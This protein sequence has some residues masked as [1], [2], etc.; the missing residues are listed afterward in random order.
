MVRFLAIL[1][2]LQAMISVRTELVTVPV[3]VTDERGAHVDGLVAGDFQIL[4][5]GRTQPIAVFHH[6]DTSVTLGI[7]VDRSQSMRAKQS[8]T[9]IA[10][11]ALLRSGRPDDELFA[12]D[13]NDRI[14][15]ALPA[16]RMFTRDAGALQ[17]ALVEVPAEGRTALYDGVAAALE[18]LQLG[19]AERRI[20]I[21]IS[22]GGDNASLHTYDQIRTQARQ[23]DVVIYGIG[24]MGVGIAEQ[25]ED[26]GLLVKLCKDSGGTAY[27]PHTPSDV[28]AHAA[29]INHAVRQQYTLGFSPGLHPDRDRFR[30][31]EVKV[32]AK[33]KGRLRVRTRAGYSLPGERL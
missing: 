32:T 33:G 26:A 14:V 30:K 24:L 22:D 27:F 19:R 3:T 29:Q 12:V 13:F 20:L 8:A 5:N 1:L 16:D 23:S 9:L 10:V 18:H 25:D 4:E 2:S 31:L 21:I 6:G 28:A 15:F 7:V 11:G 17:T